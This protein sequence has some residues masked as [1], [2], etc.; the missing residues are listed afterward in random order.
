VHP[1]ALIPVRISRAAKRRL[2]HVLGPDGRMDLVR[3]MLGHVLRTVDEAGLEIVV[4]TPAALSLPGVEVWTDE[5]AGLNGAVRAATRRIGAPVLVVH[6]DLP[7]LTVADIDAVLASPADVVIARAHDGGTNG[8]VLRELISPS[9]GPD[10]AAAH[11]SAAR[12]AGLQTHVLD[13]P[14]FARD[15]DDAAALSAYDAAC[16]RGTRP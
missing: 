6:A 2:A 13:V 9:F 15:L 3:A 7:W 8:L 5:A 1:T 4:L 12:R 10:S 11:A 16:A 14:G